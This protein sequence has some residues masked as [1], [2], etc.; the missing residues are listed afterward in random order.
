MSA[1]AAAPMIRSYALYTQKGQEKRA[2]SY[3]K[4]LRKTY[5]DIID[6]VMYPFRSYVRLDVVF[7]ENGSIK[8]LKLDLPK[9]VKAK[10]E[11]MAGIIRICGHGDEAV[12]V[13]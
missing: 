9:D 6:A 5:T 8:D 11:G 1:S 2:V 4:S 13:N 10:I 3:L 7:H 12:P